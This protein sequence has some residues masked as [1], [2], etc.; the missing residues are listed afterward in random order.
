MCE[1][2]A[3]VVD[4]LDLAKD[5]QKVEDQRARSADQKSNWNLLPK[6]LVQSRVKVDAMKM[7]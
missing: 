6:R 1:F 7:V 2:G 5:R 4:T 3:S